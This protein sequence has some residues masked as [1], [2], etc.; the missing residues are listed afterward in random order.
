MCAKNKNT[1]SSLAA[2]GMITNMSQYWVQHPFI[3]VKMSC[4]RWNGD[5]EIVL[6]CVCVY[7]AETGN[8]FRCYV[9]CA[10]L[11]TVCVEGKRNNEK[12]CQNVCDII[13]NEYFAF[14]FCNFANRGWWRWAH[15][16]S[17]ISHRDHPANIRRSPHHLP[18]RHRFQLMQIPSTCQ[19]PL[20]S[21]SPPPS[22]V[23]RSSKD[24]ILLTTWEKPTRAWRKA[25]ESGTLR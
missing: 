10:C 1:P 15:C 17:A 16:P 24:V 11:W 7:P 23:W 5:P 12:L 18:N 22:P 8:L 19:A 9:L 6:L 25:S 20:P 14:F 13:M 3:F 4:D 2:E 21:P